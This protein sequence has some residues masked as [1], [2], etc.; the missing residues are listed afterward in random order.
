MVEYLH[1]HIVVASQFNMYTC[2]EITVLL[3]GGPPALVASQS[4][5]SL[6]EKGQGPLEVSAPLTTKGKGK[7]CSSLSTSKI[8][9]KAQKRKREGSSSNKVLIESNQSL[10]HSLNTSLSSEELNSPL[11]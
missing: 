4:S 6:R 8:S 1:A 11:Q 9:R 2:N 3:L 10:P 7:E 5:S